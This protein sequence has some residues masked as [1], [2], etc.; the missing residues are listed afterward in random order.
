MTFDHVVRLRARYG[1]T[2][3]MGVIYHANYIVYFEIGRT[4]LMRSHGIRY[5][6]MERAGL[7][8]AV[9][10][11]GA[12]YLVSARYD[13]L[14]AVRTRIA[15]CTNVR[16]R[17]EYRVLR[18]DEPGEAETLLSEGHTTLAC[19]DRSGKPRRLPENEREAFARL[20][21]REFSR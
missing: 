1:E 10:D 6:D 8:L 9:V 14:L 21:G 16:V 3:Q 19:I 12:R 7:F 15:D 11:V 13:D 17:F 18:V 20:L 5:A 2:D 4:E